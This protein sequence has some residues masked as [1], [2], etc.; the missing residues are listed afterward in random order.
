MVGVRAAASTLGSE[1][2]LD[3]AA[4]AAGE[5]R[6]ERAG[7][8]E[9]E[10]LLAVERHALVGMPWACPIAP[11]RCLSRAPAE[12]SAL[13]GTMLGVCSSGLSG[14]ILALALPYGQLMWVEDTRTGQ[15]ASAVMQSQVRPKGRRM[16]VTGA[17]RGALAWVC[18]LKKPACSG[19]EESGGPT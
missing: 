5:E 12:D 9:L 15:S 11:P 14:G 16:G 4:L 19:K 10:Q 13:C 7:A 2:S 17:G 8:L 3:T 6:W 18:Q 1:L